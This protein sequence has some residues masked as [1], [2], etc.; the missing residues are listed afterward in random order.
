MLHFVRVIIE[1]AR[2]VAIGM[3]FLLAGGPAAA[4]VTCDVGIGIADPLTPGASDLAVDVETGFSFRRTAALGGVV[5]DA[6]GR[7]MSAAR[8]LATPGV[9]GRIRL[10]G[11]PGRQVDIDLPRTAR[12]SRRQGGGI[13]IA[14]LT[15]DREAPYI[16]GPD[17]YLEVDFTG[18]LAITG[19]VPPGDYAG[20][21]S[22]RADYR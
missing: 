20:E 12:L 4:C 17:G 1:N 13:D 14:D 2:P 21:V 8:P 10:S 6:A 19:P 18:T 15:L 11:T 7:Q 3:T 9:V 16:L 5:F 22:V